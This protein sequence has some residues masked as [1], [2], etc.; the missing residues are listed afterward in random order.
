M[1]T[2]SLTIAEAIQKVEEGFGSV[3]TKEDVINLLNS[4]KE[5][6]GDK[7][8]PIHL[9]IDGLE[10][11]KGKIMD[12]IMEN[13]DISV[14]DLDS[15]SLSIGYNNQVEIDDISLDDSEVERIIGRSINEVI[16]DLQADA[17]ETESE[18]K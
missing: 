10:K 15:A 6:D 18:N 4:I 1:K 8:T 3:Y 5:E 12:R 14:V 11:I 13:M 7:S 16:A 2:N 9:F 17:E